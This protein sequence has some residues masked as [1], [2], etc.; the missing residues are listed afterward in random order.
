MARRLQIFCC[1]LLFSFLAIQ[2]ASAQLVT[3]RTAP[4]S[5]QEQFYNFPSQLLGMGGGLALKDLEADPFSNPATGAR[6]K[7]TIISGTPTMYNMP[8]DDGFGR[9]L[10]VAIMSGSDNAF[11]VFSLA[12]QEIESAQ[13]PRF[14]FGPQPAGVRRSDRFSHNLYTSG[15]IGQ[16][17]AKSRS[18]IAVSASYAKLDA[19]HM[20]DLLYPDADAIAQGGHMSDVRIG[21]LKE[22]SDERYLEAVVLRNNVDMEHTVTY[23]DRVWQPQQMQWVTQLPR[24]EFNEDNT[25]TWGAHVAY[26]RPMPASEWRVAG[27][28]TANA[29][30]HPHIPNYEFMRIPRDPGHSWA[31][32]FG[33]GAA[34]VRE[35]SLLAF[36]ISYEPA[37]TSTWAEAATQTRTA[38]GGTIPVGG[39]TV[40]NEM[41]FSNTNLH[42]G[43][44]QS[45]DRNFAVQLGLGVR[46][47]NYWLYQYSHI[48]ERDRSQDEGWTEVTPS[49]GLRLGFS[50]LELRYFGQHRGGGLD[51]GSESRSEVM[52]PAP[53]GDIDVVAAPSSPLSMDVVPVWL[54]QFGVAIPIGR[55]R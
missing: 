42:V 29:K 35:T 23:V 53:G 48:A 1:A 25:T 37:W 13:R 26:T 33:V 52:V 45:L 50:D 31:F 11:M 24:E 22:F 51:F 36:D 5:V 46:R 3:V 55:G 7:G 44:Q 54:H 4:V 17:F 15:A 6:I 12:P 8:Q 18:A 39:V 47:V 49:W 10:P 9:A 21:Y 32:R 40:E 2:S 14:F 34:R 38:S 19:V 28:L 27:A 16:K 41:V 30:S 43:W 20:V